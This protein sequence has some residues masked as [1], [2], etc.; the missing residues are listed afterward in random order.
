MSLLP[1]TF[2]QPAV[3]R[4]DNASLI[5]LREQF[6][7]D[8]INTDLSTLRP[9]I[10]RSWQR[11]MQSNVSTGKRVLDAMAE[12]ELDEH[13]L[14]AAEPALNDLERLFAEA[15]GCLSLCDPRGTLAVYRG[16]HSMVKVADRLFPTLG[17]RMS[18]SLLGTNSDGTAIEEGCAV[19]VW[20]GEHF[21][22][23][24]QD[25]CCTSVLI[26][27]PLHQGVRGVLSLTLP[28]RFVRGLDPRTVMFILQ[29]AASEIT[30]AL[31][32]RIAPGEQAMLGAYLR[33]VRKRGAE[34][35]VVMDDHTTI[36]SRAATQL[37]EQSDY[38]VLSAFAREA[39]QYNRPS[40]HQVVCGP[41]RVLQL[42]VAPVH[43]GNP[44]AGSIIKVKKFDTSDTRI[45]VS[46]PAVRGSRFGAL[47][48]ESFAIRRAVESAA[49]AV[50]Q[51]IGAYV[52]GE[53]GTGKK[54]IAQM[55]AQQLRTHVESFDLG[56]RGDVEALA[57]HLDD[58]LSDDSRA[59]LIHRV[60]LA[61]DT[62]LERLVAVLAGVD[63]PPV[64][65]TVRQITDRLLALFAAAKGVDIRMPPLRTRREDIPL[66]AQS[67]AQSS[68][69]GRR[70]SAR[71]LD[72]L[73]SAEW[74]DNV[75]ELREVIEGA[76]LRS[77]G[78]EIRVDD[79]T[80]VHKRALARS[81]L[82]PLQQA[83]LQ[84][85]RDALVEAGGNR[86]RAAA[87]LRIARSTLYRKI[88]SYESRGFDLGIAMH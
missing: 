48:G 16:A 27:D 41:D 46:C 45:A 52:S 14:R 76:A 21:N 38:A 49:A 17:G 65:L 40:E 25:A 43:A 23:A 67:F 70:V 24:F 39:K 22:E 56:R 42:Q 9:V 50:E 4:P 53:P 73:A 74:T 63:R 3:N 44:K 33:E 75:R 51:G 62:V 12:P 6:V 32:A 87:I 58:E 77:T 1:L 85:I 84:Q 29:G 86:Q 57:R 19:Q 47:V 2:G 64:V 5:E 15:N 31:A 81:R 7:T 83:E 61:S 68:Q 30:G 18:E 54:F 11:S 66:L 13:F 59:L 37:L 69:G 8:P 80:E 88:D 72:V 28:E 78:A 82:S 20:G 55:I 26:R 36:A 34:A 71:L 10:A 79:L 35:V 60:D